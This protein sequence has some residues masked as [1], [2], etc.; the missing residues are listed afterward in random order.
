MF[1]GKERWDAAGKHCYI[2]GGSSGLGLA[3]AKMLAEQGAHVTIV[4]RDSKRLSSALVEIETF[5][6]SENQIFQSFSYSLFTVGD[7]RA[8]LEAASARHHGLTPDAV[9]LCAGKAIPRFFVEYTE[10]ELIDGM[11]YGYWVQAWTAWIV[12]RQMVLQKRTGS[13]IFVSSTL[14]LMTVPGYS[15]YSP[16]KHALRG[17]AD[18]LRCELLLY[19]IDT[20]IFFPPTM[21]TPSYEEENKIKPKITLK[22]EEADGG[23]TAEQAAD[24]LLKGFKKGYAHITADTLTDSFRVST[25]GTAPS[26]NWIVDGLKAVVAHIWIPVWSSLTDRRVKAHREEHYQHLE[27]IGFFAV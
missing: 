22:I 18:T 2:T 11:N 6:R 26:H 21:F 17:L 24:G 4:A 12:T 16:C 13:I 9:F 27:D 19:G 15:G 5:R 25:R 20:H 3:L 8:A 1:C 14:G 10:A 23:L 7:S